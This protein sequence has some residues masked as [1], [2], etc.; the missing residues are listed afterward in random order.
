MTATAYEQLSTMSRVPFEDS[1]AGLMTPDDY[2][3]WWHHLT[4]GRADQ[5][6]VLE[7]LA[8]CLSSRT[9]REFRPMLRTGVG[10]YDF[11][12]FHH[13]HMETDPELALYVHRAHNVF[14]PVNPY[15][16]ESYEVMRAYGGEPAAIGDA[17]R[18]SGFLGPN[19]NPDGTRAAIDFLPLHVN[20][21]TLHGIPFDW[22]IRVAPQAGRI[23]TSREM[24]AFHNA[25]WTPEDM[26]ALTEMF[27][28]VVIASDHSI[29]LFNGMARASLLAD[30]GPE[31]A[32]ILAVSDVPQ[33]RLIEAAAGDVP[34]EYL[35][36]L[37]PAVAPE[38][39]D[40][41]S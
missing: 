20:A 30:L 27:M 25:G 4:K 35:R 1:L 24:L 2:Y 32:F 11:S 29:P 37:H 6:E 23:R 40:W 3:D 13:Y 34:A 12:L 17:M 36:L 18:Y 28:H 14:L 5:P 26:N 22:A 10:V 41:E 16:I 9:S 8:A 21:V 39:W 15:V 38:N 19:N 33:N 31:T 7:A